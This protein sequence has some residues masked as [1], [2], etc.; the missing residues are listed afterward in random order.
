M[1]S[2]A[3][4][5]L[6]SANER[7]DADELVDLAKCMFSD[8]GS[9]E[10]LERLAP[11]SDMAALRLAYA[12]HDVVAEFRKSLATGRMHQMRRLR[13]GAT[14][15][16]VEHRIARV[17]RRLA[18]E[19][20]NTRDEPSELTKKARTSRVTSRMDPSLPALLERLADTFLCEGRDGS[21]RVRSR[22]LSTWQRLILA[23]PPL[24][25]CAAFVAARISNEQLAP[26]NYAEQCRL[27]ERLNRWLCDSTLPVDDNPFLD[28]LG[29][30]EGFDEVHMHLN[31]TTEAEKIWMDALERP[32]QVVGRYM[33]HSAFCQDS[34]LVVSIGNGVRRLLHQEDASLTPE[35]LLKRTLKAIELKTI[36]MEDL[37][38]GHGREGSTPKRRSGDTGVVTAYRNVQNTILPQAVAA[39]LS[40]V[41]KETWQLVDILQGLRRPQTSDGL[42]VVFWHYCLVRAQFCRLLVQQA[43]QKGFDQF[44]YITLNE[45]REE[46][47]KTFAERFRQIE[48]GHQQDVQYVEGRFAPKSSPDATAKLIGQVVRGYLEFLSE[49]AQGRKV[50]S[51]GVEPY[52]SLADLLKLVAR[53]EGRSPDDAKGRALNFGNANSSKLSVRRLRIGLVAHFIK[54]SSKT[55]RDTFFRDAGVRPRCR[56]FRL[57][58]ETDQR[59][60]ALVGL[61]ERTSGLD[62]LLRGIDAASNERHAGPE[63]FAPTYRR[64]RAAGI[65]RF[66]YHAGEDF[67]HLA[68]GLRAITEA[69]TFLELGA[70]CRIGHG[71]AAG[72]SPKKWWKSVGGVVVMPIEDRLDDIVLAREFFLRERLG[73]DRLPHLEAEIHRLA[74]RIWNDPRI[75][76]QILASAWKMRA[77]DPLVR[78][79]QTSDVDHQKRSEALKHQVAKY[80]EPLAYAHFMRRHGIGADVNE[81][82]RAREDMVV[83][84]TDDVL[85]PEDLRLLQQSVLRLVYDQRVALETLP[86]SNIRISIHESYDDH[87]AGFWLG[88][89]K[90]RSL[91]PVDVVVGSDDPGIFA[92]ALRNEYSHLLRMLEAKRLED[93]PSSEDVLRRVCLAAKQYRF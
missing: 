44:Q 93:D 43:T 88:V 85:R 69:V 59:A 78:E 53:H 3:G 18:D 81:L 50:E 30:T 89:G 90:K 82:R 31:G 76:P 58:T 51:R 55:D 7:F 14:D 26:A 4:N 64:M 1:S 21:I 22:H 39:R 75:T 8:V 47:E 12:K 65:S 71:T 48:R 5:S 74:M 84:V 9:I 15:E 72:L 35:K 42:Q 86:S 41:A 40:R 29:A 91:V 63:V 11:I 56:D 45:L 33:G 87:H 68:S 46:S 70:G 2:P 32:Q 36:L 6:L 66:T 49:D 83:S 92:T 73:G 60:R 16:A 54:Q 10:T 62:A 80:H 37:S 38:R 25:I 79:T 52:E 34:G 27:V 57:R 28:H 19:E 13:P 61:I 23:V 24:L 77:L 20:P 17:L 67:A